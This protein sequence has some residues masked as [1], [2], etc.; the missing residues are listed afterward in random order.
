MSKNDLAIPSRL[1]DIVRRNRELFELGF[2]TAA[3]LAAVTGVLDG[4]GSPRGTIDDWRIIALRDHVAKH[5][6]LHVVGRFE[7]ARA[8]MTSEIAMIAADESTVRTRNSIYM[9]GA[10]AVGEPDPSLLFH[11]T[12]V[13]RWWGIDER[14][15]LGA[16]EWLIETPL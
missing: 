15:Q 13:L 1:D 5:V 9:L 2:A 11:I 7:N 12:F 8:W 3:E 16:S 6:T 4:S 10:R 14:Y